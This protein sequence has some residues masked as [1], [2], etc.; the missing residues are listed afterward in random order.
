MALLLTGLGALCRPEGLVAFG[1]NPQRLTDE[2]SENPAAELTFVFKAGQIPRCLLPAVLDC[3]LRHLGVVQYQV[4]HV[5][6][7]VAAP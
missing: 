3:V 7:G 6:K 2:K 4:C 1:R 5:M